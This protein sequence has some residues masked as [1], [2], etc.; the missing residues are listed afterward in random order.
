MNRTGLSHCRMNMQGAA[1]PL[2]QRNDAEERKVI[3]STGNAQ[4][5]NINQLRKK[6]AE[7]AAQD[8][9]IAEGMKMLLEA[10]AE[11]IRKIYISES[12]YEKYASHKQ[13]AAL[14]KHVPY[15]ITSDQVFESM[16]D[17]KTPQGVLCLIKQYHYREDDLL[18]GGFM[19]GS[20]QTAPLC[21]ILEHLQDPGNLG[22]IMRTA[23]GAGVTGILMTED[24]VDL[25]N[26][27]V[28][29]S[30]MGSI[31][32]MPFLYTD[33][34]P[35]VV[36]RWKEK[37][38]TVYAAHLKGQNT[39]DREDYRKGSA[40]LIGNESR[41][42]TEETAALADCRVKIPMLGKVESLN[43]AVASSVLMYEA[44]RQR[45]V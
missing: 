19:A 14:L 21:M 36:N 37:G 41:G 31:Y 35:G 7:R 2:I 17:T 8:L 40:F 43:A 26:P 10:P 39:Y 9:F 4:I 25:T 23:E 5:R 1:A 44:A 3:T 28:I 6:G 38:I 30:T 42:L 12:F 34:L 16:S 33:D 11:Q 15:E 29:R 27:K 24:C 32:R 18:E 13:A 22:T 45:R 20:R